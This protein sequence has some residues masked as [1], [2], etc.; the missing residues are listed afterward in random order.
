MSMKIVSNIYHLKIENELFCL[1][2]EKELTTKAIYLDVN[3]ETK[4]GIIRVDPSI[5]CA[6]KPHQIEGVKFMWD[7]V[8]ERVEMIKNGHKGSGCILAHCM[9]LGKTLQV[10][11]LVHT[12]I[13]NR[14]LTNVNRVL[15]LMPVNVLTNWR[16]EFNMWT[17]GCV[18]KLFIYELPSQNSIEK[19]LTMQRV[20]ELAEWYEKGG[21]FLISYAMFT[22]L[23]QG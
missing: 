7:S 18:D 1:M 19:S 16:R 20:D 22:R 10:V 23:L 21:V 17:Q 13:V 3:E 14:H 11:S 15:I 12:L 4:K 9:G 6:M 8:F 2:G 5:A